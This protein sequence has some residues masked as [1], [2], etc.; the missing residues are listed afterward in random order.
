[1]E[2][3]EKAPGVLRQNQLRRADARHQCTGRRDQKVSTHRIQPPLHCELLPPQTPRPTSTDTPALNP[4][5]VVAE[6]PPQVPIAFMMEYIKN[7]ATA[8][9][10]GQITQM[11]A[12][13]ISSG[14]IVDWQGID[15]DSH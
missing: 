9:G 13:D 2:L 4:L 5:H 11:P 8:R 7:V 15:R 10:C 3:R 6:I 1:M 14:E 12:Q